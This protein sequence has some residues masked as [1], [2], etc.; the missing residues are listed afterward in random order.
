M[1]CSHRYARTCFFIV[2]ST[3]LVLSMS[4]CKSKPKATNVGVLGSRDLVPPPYSRP[5]AAAPSSGSISRPV[6]AQD[7]PAIASQS[8]REPVLPV[9]E[10]FV[11]A[12]SPV[13]VPDENIPEPEKIL[14]TPVAASKV[15]SMVSTPVAVPATTPASIENL[16]KYQIQKGDT[17]SGIAQCVGVKWQD[18]AALNPSVNPNRMLVGETLVLPAHAQDKP[19]VM[20]KRSKVARNTATTAS[21]IKVS[22]IPSDGV[23]T[24]VSGDSL[25]TISRRFKVSS[26]DIRTWNNLKTDKLVIGQKLK[27]KGT[28]TVKETTPKTTLKTT[29]K[30]AQTVT[31]TPAAEVPV[32]EN[33][34]PVTP[35]ILTDETIV[36]PVDTLPA[37]A[38]NVRAID[39]LIS[40]NDTLESIAMLYE[41]KLE[42]LLRSNPNIKSN[43]DLVPNA[44]I[45]I[46][47]PAKK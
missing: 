43:A 1:K 29:E 28:A 2:T 6:A 27:L 33:A 20:P 8:D 31:P 3:A 10:A 35:E 32:A 36:T 47:Y 15:T 18:I 34:T 17:L 42:D 4:A 16:R 12:E 40:E 19:I 23:Y 41:V 9:T 13:Y 45:K 21:K 37:E 24:V 14:S 5:A 44:T 26:D 11:P 38:A 22:S 25:W 30:S 46:A 39:H 7:I